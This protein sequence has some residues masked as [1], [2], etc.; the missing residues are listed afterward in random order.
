MS[1]NSSMVDPPGITVLVVVGKPLLPEDW[2]S[3]CFRRIGRSQIR[4]RVGG[5]HRGLVNAIADPRTMPAVDQPGQQLIDD[6]VVERSA[7]AGRVCT[8]SK[9]RLL[10]LEGALLGERL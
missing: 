7:T 8:A 6:V 2:V 9:H 3:G 1:L 10:N 4:K 5:P